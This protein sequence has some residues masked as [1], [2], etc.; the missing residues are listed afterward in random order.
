MQTS[1]NHN[2]SPSDDP[3]RQVFSRQPANPSVIVADGY[4]VSVTVKRGH[5]VIEDGLS[6]VRRTRRIP[7]VDGSM[8]VRSSARDL[9]IARLVIL[10]GTGYVSLDALEWCS[11]LGITVTQVSQSGKVLMSSPG[12]SGDSRLR[13]AQ[14]KALDT[15]KATHIVR[16]ITAAKLEGQ[17]KVLQDVFGLAHPAAKILDIASLVEASESLATI[18]AQEG[19]AANI[20]WR[21]W[22]KRV[23]V[24][25]RPQDLQHVP[26]HWWQF[27]GR[28]SLRNPLLQG[29]NATDPVNSLLNFAYAICETEAR[30]ACQIIGLDPGIGFGHGHKGGDTLVFDLMEV[31]RPLSDRVVLSMMDTGQGVPYDIDGKPAYFK[32]LSFT[33][34]SDGIC[35]LVP[36]L[37]HQL[38]ELIPPAVAALAGEYAETIARALTSKIPTRSYVRKASPSR[39]QLVSASKL[40]LASSDILPDSIWSAVSPLIPAE[41]LSTRFKP[42]SRKPDRTVLAGIL[43]HEI[44]GV[45]W[46]SIPASFGVRGETCRRRLAEWETV[47]AWLSIV[48]EF[49]K[50]SATRVVE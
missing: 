13:I 50:Q 45:S 38:A 41:P 9:R 3:I 21:S 14:V 12:L 37:T 39:L 35:R 10:S 36:P 33:E 19:N 49:R 1:V 8:S 32:L 27:N 20:Y 5:L 16:S 34:T 48:A 28:A 47:G 30:H 43:C 29:K 46:H 2:N 4:G 11:E 17:A 18:L 15:P 22:R 31:L 40:A 25:F 7:R 6:N 44:L 24:P 26:S 42:E 23:F